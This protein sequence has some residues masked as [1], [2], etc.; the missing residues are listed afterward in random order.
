VKIQVSSDKNVAVDTE[1]T[2]VVGEEVSRVLKRFAG[3]LT[4]VEVHL[5]DVN[6]RKFGTHDKRCLIEARPAGHRPLTARNGASTVGE[7]VRGALTKLRSSLQ[8]SFGR[9][10]KRSEDTTIKAENGRPRTGLAPKDASSASAALD[11]VGHATPKGTKR[12][13]GTARKSAP[14]QSLGHGRDPK[15]KGIYQARRKSWPAR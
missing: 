11:G 7:A 3:K 15:K 5:S 2:R 12:S 8:T 4:R 1:M 10:G 14:D 13:P 6:S 9:L